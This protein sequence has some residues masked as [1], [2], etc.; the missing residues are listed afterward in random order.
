MLVVVHTDHE[1]LL[2][3]RSEP[4]EFWQSVTGSLLPGESHAVAAAREL[5]EE[6]GLTGEGMLSCTGVSRRFVIDPRWR[7]RFGPGVTENLEH[8]YRFKLPRRVGITLSESEH[9]A[10]EWVA[11]PDAADRVWSWT[12]KAALRRLPVL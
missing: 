6:T 3:R 8:E 9:T 11:L 2:L 7:W 1:A 12:N 4:F 10:M 5:R